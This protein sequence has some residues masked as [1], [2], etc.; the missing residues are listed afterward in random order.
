MEIELAI[1]ADNDYSNRIRQQKRK[2]C[3]LFAATLIFGV[4]AG[5]YAVVHSRYNDPTKSKLDQAEVGTLPSESQ[6]FAFTLENLGES[7]NE[8][9]TIF[10]ETMPDWAPKGVDRFH[11]SVHIFQRQR[12]FGDLFRQGKTRL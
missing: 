6:L 4:V 2:T 11:V 10:I 9:G 7:S 5:R 8:T 3:L 12:F 1:D